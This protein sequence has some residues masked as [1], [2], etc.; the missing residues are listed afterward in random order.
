MAAADLHPPPQRDSRGSPPAGQEPAS[1][2]P[3]QSPELP[4]LHFLLWCCW[5]CWCWRRSGRCWPC[6][7]HCCCCC[8]PSPCRRPYTT[9]RHQSATP[10]C[11][12]CVWERGSSY[13]SLLGQISGELGLDEVSDLPSCDDGHVSACLCSLWT[14]WR[15][16]V[17]PFDC[18]FSRRIT[19]TLNIS[20]WYLLCLSVEPSVLEWRRGKRPD[21]L[22]T[23]LLRG[24]LADRTGGWR[25]GQSLIGPASYQDQTASNT[26]TTGQQPTPATLNHLKLTSIK[27]NSSSATSNLLQPTSNSLN[28]A[29]WCPCTDGEGA[30]GAFTG[31]VWKSSSTQ[32]GWEPPSGPGGPLA[33]GPPH[34]LHGVA[35]H[36]HGPLQHSENSSGHH[37]QS[38]R[39]FSTVKIMIRATNWEVFERVFRYPS[40]WMGH[41]S[42]AMSKFENRFIGSTVCSFALQFADSREGEQKTTAKA[43]ARIAPPLVDSGK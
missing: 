30:L 27:L 28:S 26:R 41:W 20:D 42:S 10:P 6:L 18:L 24:D 37:G 2:P 40:F 29:P 11:P 33:L 19:M 36:P 17:G 9:R 4:E 5:S 25:G 35:P 14:Q 7:H 39:L 8:A 43:A 15:R 38:D 22:F 23:G 34:G 13:L 31:A 12:V 16:S 1:H 32:A 3:S 21:L